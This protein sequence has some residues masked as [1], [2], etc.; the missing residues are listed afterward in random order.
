MLQPLVLADLVPG[1]PTT[2]GAWTLV[3][4]FF[5]GM[6]GA[7]LVVYLARQVVIPEFRP[8][9]DTDADQNELLRLRDQIATIEGQIQTSLGQ[10]INPPPGA[11]GP[12]MVE[13]INSQK[14]ILDTD[15]ARLRT[16]ESRLW[17]TQVVSRGLGFLRLHSSRR[18]DRRPVD[19]ESAS[20]RDRR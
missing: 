12:T 10:L 15:R 20:R 5:L 17:W 3:E 7:L 13:R 4:H 9:F 18:G 1:G 6:L 14:M 11:H 16:V 19:R 2:L 8:F